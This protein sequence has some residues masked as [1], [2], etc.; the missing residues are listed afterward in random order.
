MLGDHGCR[1]KAL[2]Y[3][4]AL[5]VPLVIRP[6]GGVAGEHSTALTDHLDLVLTMLEIAGADSL[7]GKDY[8][9]SLVDKTLEGPQVL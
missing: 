2:F 1:N 4:A 9:T 3:E 5:R 8:R 6:P 7:F